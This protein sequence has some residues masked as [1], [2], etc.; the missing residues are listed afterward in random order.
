MPPV[1]EI[2]TVVIAEFWV[3]LCED[4][5]NV[6]EGAATE[7]ANELPPLLKATK[8]FTPNAKKPPL[9]RLLVTEDQLIPSELIFMVPSAAIATNLSPA[10]MTCCQFLPLE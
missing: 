4:V 2:V 3:T 5:D 6:K 7:Y 10:Y 1:D 9:P 8:L